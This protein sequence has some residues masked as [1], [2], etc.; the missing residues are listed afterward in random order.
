[1]FSQRTHWASTPNNLSLLTEKLQTNKIPFLDLTESNPTRC[2]LDYPQ[3]KILSVLKD[4]KNIFYEPS[5]FGKKES[6]EAVA[7]Y[8]AQKGFQV[9]PA[10]VFLTASTSES[11][12]FLFRLLTEPKDNILISQPSYP[13]FDFLAQLNDVR[14]RPYSLI[15]KDHWSVDFESLEKSI[16]ESTKAIVLVN[17]HNPTGS[18]IK[19]RE[20]EALNK[21][22]QAKKIALICDEVFSDYC[23]VEGG[24]IVKSLVDN[25]QALTFVLSGISKILALP[26]MKL[27]WGIING[28]QDL[29]KEALSRLEIILDTYLSVNTPVQNALS[30]W[31]SLRPVIQKD[32]G[33][34]LAGNRQTIK[35]LLSGAEGCRY[36]H[37][38][39]G[40]YAVLSLPDVLSE[41]EWI[42]EFLEKDHVLVH[43]GYFFDFQEEPY[44][45]I[46]LL[47]FP[48][49]L[50]DGLKKI[51]K[52]VQS[53]LQ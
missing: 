48:K 15:Y 39:G 37:S 30:K 6:R 7:R 10:R 9:D 51:L 53:R 14:I 47:T 36:L 33:G 3:S 41:E 18:F 49:T 27:G 4:S 32:I 50:E 25:N 11:Y 5:A 42:L 1:M 2:R 17:P 44:I 24:E 40:W 46:S 13:L 28:P 43:P 34:R 26:Q 22:C 8:Y 38:E 12:S 21:I 52:R 35:R 45:V 19:R 16:D 29:V 23:F 20:L 31:F